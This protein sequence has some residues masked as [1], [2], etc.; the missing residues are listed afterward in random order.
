V[1]GPVD[2]NGPDGPDGHF[3][4]WIDGTCWWYKEEK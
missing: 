1:I 2:L 4:Q 3:V